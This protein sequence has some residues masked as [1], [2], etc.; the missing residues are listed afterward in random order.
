MD[1]SA[2]SLWEWTKLFIRDPRTAARLVKEADLPLEVAVMMM[3]LAGVVSA[4]ISGVHS[5]MIGSPDRVIQISETHAMSYQPIGPLGQGLFA[6]FTG[7]GLAYVI[8]RLGRRMG[9]QGSLPQIMAVLAVLQLVTTIL[10][11]G[12]FTLVLILPL[13]GNILSI[14]IVYVFVRGL[15]HA[16]N[17]G[18][19]LHSMGKSV[20]VIVGAILA[21]SFV[22]AAIGVGALMVLTNMGLGPEFTLVPLSEGLSL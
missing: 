18:H 13:A 9:G 15:G 21:L 17:E 20:W 12:Q 19:A 14:F 5:V 1:L 16:V 6:V 10:S 3:V 22:T 8:F 2:A 4:A 7:V 11:V